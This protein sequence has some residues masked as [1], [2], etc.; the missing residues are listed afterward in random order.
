VTHPFPT[1]KGILRPRVFGLGSL[2]PHRT[3]ELLI[4]LGDHL[5]SRSIEDPADFDGETFQQFHT[6]LE[7]TFPNV[8]STLTWETVNEYSLLYRWAGADPSLAP[9]GILAHIDVVPVEPGTEDNWTHGAYEGRLDDAITEFRQFDEGNEC[10]TCAYPWLAR[11]F[12]QKG[13]ADSARVYFERFVETPSSNVWYDA[14][15]LGYSYLRLGQLFEE[16]GEPEKTASYL[17]RFAELW[18]DADPDLQPR[19]E[20]ARQAIERLQ[21]EPGN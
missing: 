12:D 1:E 17:R 21:K 6:Y 19:V 11:A 5:G 14:A 9:M 13:R 7:E 20:A 18:A 2:A 10:S 8:H 3:L 4:P 15:H 16:R